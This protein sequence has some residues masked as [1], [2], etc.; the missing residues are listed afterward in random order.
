[1]GDFRTTPSKVWQ[2]DIPTGFAVNVVQE[3][4]AGEPDA[5]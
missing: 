2:E 3:E 5:G 4:A 1:M